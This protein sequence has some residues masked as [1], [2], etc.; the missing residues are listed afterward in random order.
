[1]C[2][3]RD[4]AARLPA[5][6]EYEAARATLAR[7]R[8]RA[9][10]AVEVAAAS[11]LSEGVKL[12]FAHGA[13]GRVW[14]LLP[15][16]GASHPAAVSSLAELSAL[17][18]TDEEG[19]VFWPL[20]RDV[21]ELDL[22]ASWCNGTAGHALLWTEI[23]RL[24]KNT[25]ALELARLSIESLCAMPE[26]V[27][28]ICCGLAGHSLAL[29]RYADLTGDAKSARRAYDRLARA[30]AIYE[31]SGEILFNFWQGWMG[32]ALVAMNRLRGEHRLPL[33]EPIA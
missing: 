1:V 3:A 21:W 7:V 27:P 28:G 17:R 25:E 31:Q 30:T 33:L 24:T 23:A 29:Q 19:L 20:A 22:V 26:R 5:G 8:A 12:G 32:V 9:I 14:S 4:L 2:L 13:A 6:A 11:P 10:A 16:G 18:E 15:D